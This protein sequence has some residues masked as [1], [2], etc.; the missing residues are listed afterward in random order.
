MHGADRDEADAPTHVIQTRNGLSPVNIARLI[1][2]QLERS[3]L[4][5]SSNSAWE[6]KRLIVA[7]GVTSDIAT[8]DVRISLNTIFQSVREMLVMDCDLFRSASCWN[9][10]GMN[11]GCDFWDFLTDLDF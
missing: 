2:G 8:N 9:W 11:V 3:F 1:Q 7:G 4:T 5:V 10:S 6:L